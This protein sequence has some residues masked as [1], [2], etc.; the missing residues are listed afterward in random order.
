M[1][2]RGIDAL[3]PAAAIACASL[4]AACGSARKSSAPEKGG[5]A[6]GGSSLKVVG[7]PAFASPSSAQPVRSGT[8]QIAYRNITIAPDTLRVKVGSTVRW[9]DY[10][11]VQHDV[12]SV[13]GPQRFASRRIG[14]GQSFAV[15]LTR[16]GTIHY[17]CTIHPATM[18]G[19]IEV[20]K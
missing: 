9:T 12:T 13:S 6:A 10:D 19:T 14:E 4:L 18:N 3:S 11:S 15:K 7:T 20:I 8:V 16:A 1:R 17:E 5:T 2:I